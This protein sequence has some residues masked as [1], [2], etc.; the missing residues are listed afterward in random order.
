[1][2]VL[3]PDAELD[4]EGVRSFAAEA[5]ASFKVPEHVE[6]VDALPY[7]AVGKVIKHLLE[8]PEQASDFV[9]E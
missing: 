7:N 2:I 8:H 1:V 6:F 9:P 3:H 5:L 4:A